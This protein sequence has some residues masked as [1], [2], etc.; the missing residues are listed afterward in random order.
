[1]SRYPMRGVTYPLTMSTTGKSYRHSVIDIDHQEQQRGTVQIQ[2]SLHAVL[3]E[4]RRKKY[5]RF[6]WIDAICI[7]QKMMQRKV[8]RSR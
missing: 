8:S 3:Q 6:L 4:L 7:N 5:S 2:S 1:M